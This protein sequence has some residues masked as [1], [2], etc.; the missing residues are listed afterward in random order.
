MAE[1]LLLT[2]VEVDGYVLHTHLL[3]SHCLCVPLVFDR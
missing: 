3:L 2:W 1:I